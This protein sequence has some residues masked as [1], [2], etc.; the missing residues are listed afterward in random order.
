MM[1]YYKDPD[2]TARVIDQD[3]WF[4]TGDMG[5]INEKGQV[6]IVGRLKNI[7]K[8][9][10]GKYVNPQAIEEKFCE[11]PFI[12]N[13]VVMGE[14][15]KFAAALIAPDFVFLKSWC[16]T[17]EVE[18]TTPEDMVK[19]EVIQKRFLRE[20]T[21]YNAFFG[22]TEQVKKFV[23]IPDEWTQKNEILTPTLKVKRDVVQKRYAKEIENL[24]N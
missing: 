1:G 20:V 18:Y 22:D 4:H 2:L 6:M 15:Q 12:D 16:A 9:S 19:N 5:K 8:T 21:K 17:H 14:N 13:M 7:F 3:G 10:F 24:F 11:S 23:L